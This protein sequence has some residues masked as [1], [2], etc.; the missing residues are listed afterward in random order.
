M[1]FVVKPRLAL[2]VALGGLASLVGLSSCSGGGSTV[3][4]TG[5]SCSGPNPRAICL[6]SCNLGCSPTGCARTDI[7]QNEIVILSFSEPIDPNSVNS[8]SIRFRTPSGDE[9]VGEFYVRDNRVEFVPTLSISGGQTFFGFTT[10]ETYTMTIVGGADQPAVVRSTSGKPF[11]RTLTCTLQSTRGIV[12]QNG[13]P[14]RATLIVPTPNQASAAPLDTD[15]QLEFNELIDFTPF[16]SGT[17]SPV[18]FAVRR[19]RA[20]VSGGRE[21]DPNSAPQTLPGTQS[22]TFDAA[23]SV[24]VLS[25]RPS[26]LLPGNVCIEV[27]ITDGV[28]DL[29]GR[30]AQPQTF[31]FLTQVVPLTDFTIRERFDDNLQL[32]PDASAA[33]WGGGFA[34]FARIG[35][36]ARHGPFSTALAFDT[37]TTIDGRRVFELN[38]NN[39]I[40][41]ASN[42]TTGSPIAVTD[43]RFFFSTMVVPSDVR[44]RFVGTV[45]PIITVSGRCEILGDIEAAG[46]SITTLP[47]FGAT[48]GQPGG[49]GGVFGGSG[50]QGGDRCSG[51]TP[52]TSANDGR[53]GQDARLL[54]G[55]AY[56]GTQIGTGGRGSRPFPTTGQLTLAHFGSPP[57]TIS[58]AVAATSGGGGGGFVE[59]GGIGLVVS[60][61]HP[62][63]S[64]FMGAPAAGGNALQLFP[65][66][67]G[68]KSSLHFLIGGAGGGGAASN[69]TMIIMVTTSQ[70][71]VPPTSPWAPGA[72]GGGGGGA[73]ALRAGDVL[74]VAPTGRLLLHGG[75]AADS[76]GSGSGVAL[77]A[78]GGGGS[79]GSLVLQSGRAAEIT[80]LID[81]RGGAG[82]DFNRTTSP[83]T[84]PGGASVQIAGGAGSKGFVRLETPTAPTLAQLASMQPAATADNIGV[85]TE[86]DDVVGCRS[87]FYS[88]GLIF[89]PEFARYEIL[90]VVDGVPTVFSD[91]PAVSTVAAGP[92][93]P[94]RALF[95]AAALDLQTGVALE[96]RPWRTSVR[97][98][99]L[100]TGIASD[101]LNGFRF[102]LFVDRAFAQDVTIDEVRVVYRN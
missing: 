21:C 43:G 47:G 31:T 92:G 82:G 56:F 18:T 68:A 77:V 16:L 44:L 1:T 2:L 52:A 95:Q 60:N 78:P 5:F 6:Q 62:N 91:D 38:C 64:Q 86:R 102:M 14:P 7:A 45:P 48:L 10:G 19:T 28:R 8:S 90:A 98:S 73:V 88:T 3:G 49:A 39:T 33:A 25:F 36:D 40:I 15:I 72:G 42:T 59:P 75:R 24:S 71:P 85:L 9:P 32:D 69:P 58:Y 26:Q 41:P 99:P 55:H 83:P 79:G 96:T 22:L 12:D 46:Q 50:G 70:P 97:S 84:P 81:V 89:G 87:R 74:R 61:N 23:R 80:G 27:G 101:G 93:A 66:P 63:P 67:A 76:L 11:E 17:Q 54:A 35:G 65:I 100:Q 13:V 30:T 51:V 4:S 20:S 37:N 29:S 94:V 34:T 53:D 57:P